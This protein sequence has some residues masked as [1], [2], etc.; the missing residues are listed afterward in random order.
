MKKFKAIMASV[1]AAAMV[2]TM[3]ACDEEPVSQGNNS[4]N[5]PASGSVPGQNS[6]SGGESTSTVSSVVRQD[7]SDSAVAAA[8]GN[9]ID[10][11]DYPD[12][13]VT[14]RIA[15]LSHWF[16]DETQP[17]SELF[18]AQYGIPENGNNPEENGQIFEN[19][20][21]DYQQ[22]F[23]KLNTLIQSGD[24][25]DIFQFEIA[26]FPYGILMN[27][28]QPI[29]DMVNVNAEKW[30]GAKDMMDLFVLG[31]KHYAAFT[32]ISFNCLMWY[33]KSNI[34]AIGA[35]DPYEL[36][37]AGEWNWNTFLDLARAWK[38]AGD[39]NYVC[40]GWAV[41]DELALSTGVP[42]VG[43]NG[44]ELVYNY[45]DPAFERA[46]TDIITVLQREELRYPRHEL[47]GW[48]TNYNAWADGTNLFYCG[49]DWDYTGTFQKYAKR[50]KWDE[51]EIKMVPFPKDPKSDK[52]YV[53][54]KQDAFM[55]VK[56][57]DNKAGVQAWLDC[58]ATAA[59][60][61]T[62]SE[63]EKERLMKNPETGWT[64]QLLDDLFAW[65]TLD[66]SSPLTFIFDFKRGLG[67][68]VYDSNEA[69]CPVL[70]PITGPYLNGDSFVQIREE[71]EGA[72]NAAIKEINDQIAKIS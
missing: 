56:G 23:D 17:A 49:G 35:D 53:N 9:L 68:T 32:E 27:R 46:M 25:P 41:E 59:L 24:S 71:N 58:L 65:K 70:A 43:T 55:F 19:I 10:K 2:L 18:K 48:G 45:N 28:Y 39:D 3:T 21:V 13:K 63:A 60:D 37:Q 54:G 30:A 38:A 66:G 62:V 12:L 22:R 5:P 15:F 42:L 64:R 67:P 14:D 52:Y 69:L 16:V 44:N 40:D 34:E 29:E 33:R 8:A 61:P 6:T 4:G 47:N 57:S 72:I 26:D 7:F 20:Y 36:F 11:L 51:D 1:M 50:F 31:G